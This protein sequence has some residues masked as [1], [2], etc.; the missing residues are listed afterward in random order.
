VS[1]DAIVAALR[2]RLAN[3]QW[4]LERSP[5][6]S[7]GTRWAGREV[8]A[9]EYLLA[10]GRLFRAAPRSR[11]ELKQDDGTCF[12]AAHRYVALHPDHFYVE[13]RALDP[14]GRLIHHGWAA[15]ATGEVVDLVWREPESREYFGVPFSAADE[16]ELLP[17]GGSSGDILDAAARRAW[18]ERPSA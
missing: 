5:E 8:L 14:W 17:E 7:V 13:G 9:L 15:T 16:A 18:R 11:G 3:Y 2:A 6:G 4:T 10:E 12:E 1:Q